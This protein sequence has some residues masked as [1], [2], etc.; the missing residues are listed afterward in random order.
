MNFYNFSCKHVWPQNVLAYYD[1][2]HEINTRFFFI[3]YCK[4]RKRISTYSTYVFFHIIII[5]P[6]Q[7]HG[8][9]AL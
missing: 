7:K 2:M 6:L 9:E 8:K 4:R 5:A 1:E 3:R